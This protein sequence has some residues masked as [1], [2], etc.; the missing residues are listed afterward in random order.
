MTSQISNRV[1]ALLFSALLSV[2]SFMA[3]TSSMESLVG[4]SLSQLQNPTAESYINC[5]AQLQRVEAMYPDSVLPKYQLALQSLVF[6]VQNPADPQASSM[7]KLAEQRIRSLESMP[8]VDASNL[9][10]LQGFYYTAVIVQTPSLA[11]TCYRDALDH[12][13]KAL[14]LNPDNA[15]ARNLQAQFMAN[16]P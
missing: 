11:P 2:Q 6:V 9:H 5:V 3:Q 10:T 4:Q 15:L 12:F 16:M 14:Q 1:I 8:A 13:E 7:L